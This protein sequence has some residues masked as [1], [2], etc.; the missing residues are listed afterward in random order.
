MFDS[1]R[2]DKVVIIGARSGIGLATASLLNGA[3]AELVL[4]NRD[5][6]ALQTVARTF[7]IKAQLH[8]LDV[9]DEAEVEQF[10]SEVGSFDHLVVSAAGATL[11]P[12]GES[13]SE[14]IAALVDSKFWGQT[15]AVKYGA[16]QI[17]KTGSITLFSGTVSQKPLPGTSAY[18][19][20]GS[21]IEAA[22][23]VW[24]LEYAPIRINTIVPGIIDTPVWV[25]LAGKEGAAA[26]LAQTAEILPVKGNGQSSRMAF[27]GH[28]L[29][30]NRNGLLVGACLTRATGTAEREAALAL[31]DAHRP[32]R[33]RITLGADKAYVDVVDRFL[34]SV[35]DG[36]A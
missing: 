25:N 16:R 9:T 2:N 1:I 12:L 26:Q 10:F 7:N 5:L 4:A 22:S 33:R 20:V 35:E 31:L 3:G 14:N 36:S 27:M 8:H 21:A 24:A 32:G 29:M 17:A 34:S 23:R 13:K 6:D 30:E 19:A 28:V 18:A 15:Y 11:G